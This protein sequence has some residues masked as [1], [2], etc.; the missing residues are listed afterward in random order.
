MAQVRLTRE[1]ALDLYFPGA[2]VERR[3]SFLTDAQVSGIEE[4]GRAKVESRVLTYY[5]ARNSAGVV[6]TAFFETKTVRTMPA[7]FVVV[8]APDTTVTAVEILAFHEP[9]DYSPTK[10]WLKQFTGK[11]PEDDLF[12]KR[13]IRVIAG[14]T[15]TAQALTD[16]VRRLLATY[17]IVCAQE[18]KK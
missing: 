13:G 4:R 1:Q 12:L 2:T 15:L 11:S 6:G 17:E 16:A 5:T 9:E 18:G 14:A 7:T 3:T 10:P 8:I